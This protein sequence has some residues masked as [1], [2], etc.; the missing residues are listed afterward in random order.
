MIIFRRESFALN[1]L[2]FEISN[3]NKKTCLTIDCPNFNSLGPSKF[4][5][6]AESGTEQIWYYNRNRKDK[7]FNRLLSLRQE[8]ANDSIFEIKNIVEENK[9]GSFDYY[10]INDNSSNLKRPISEPSR[11]DFRGGKI[12]KKK[13]RFPSK[14]EH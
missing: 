11:H 8:T 3:S 4:R 2:Y 13:T 12:N 6:N 9:T 7:S 14:Q 1:R 5:T 10:D